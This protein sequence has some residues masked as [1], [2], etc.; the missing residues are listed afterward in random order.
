MREDGKDHNK[1]GQATCLLQ[2][3]MALAVLLL[4]AGVRI[5]DTHGWLERKDNG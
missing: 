3:V 1:V 5:A 2:E 4:G